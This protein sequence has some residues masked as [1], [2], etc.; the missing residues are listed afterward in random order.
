MAV[1]YEMRVHQ[2][3][4]ICEG[5]SAWNERNSRNRL[6]RS[7]RRFHHC[8]KYKSPRNKCKLHQRIDVNK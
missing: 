2:S 8:S 1:T 4:R 3:I 7:L 6:L 5:Y